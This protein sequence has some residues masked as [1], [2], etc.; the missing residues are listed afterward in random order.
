MATAQVYPM[1]VPVS[2]GAVAR[3]GSASLRA[4]RLWAYISGMNPDHDETSRTIVRNERRQILQR[5]E[6]WLEWPMLVLGLGWLALLIIELTGNLSPVLATAL[7]VIWVIFIL[8]FLLSFM[9]APEKWR[10]LRRNW[11][12]LIALALPAL[13]IFRIF[14]ALRIL[15]ITRATRGLRLV[16]IFTSLN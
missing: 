1:G 6:G 12:T 5:L 9:L 13:R 8:E 14:R 10:Y 11:L 16:R 4:S 15:R 7:N 2:T 3:Q